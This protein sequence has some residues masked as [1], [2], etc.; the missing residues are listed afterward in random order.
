M[1]ARVADPGG[2]PGQ[3]QAACLKRRFRL[4]C[5][6]GIVHGD[7]PYRVNTQRFQRRAVVNRA[8]LIDHF[9]S[10]IPDEDMRRPERRVSPVACEGKGES[11]LRIVCDDRAERV[12]DPDFVDEKH[13]DPS[14]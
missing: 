1:K 2:L 5:L 10:P 8:A 7:H 6:P 11:G 9:H 3:I 13:T 14:L 12:L 4:R